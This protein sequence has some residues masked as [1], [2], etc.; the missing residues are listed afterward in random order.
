MQKFLL[1]RLPKMP[2]VVTQVLF[3]NFS[4]QIMPITNQTAGCAAP[5]AHRA[6]LA[7]EARNQVG[8]ILARTDW[9]QYWSDVSAQAKREIDAYET[10]CARSL[11]SASR[12]FVH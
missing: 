5:H 3:L 9:Q 10:A 11:A 12:K 8:S 2:I 4:S 6:D 1:F 7:Q